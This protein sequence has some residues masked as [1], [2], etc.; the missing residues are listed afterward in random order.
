MKPRF[1]IDEN[2][3]LDI[4]PGVRRHDA[5]IDITHVGDPGAPPFRTPDPTIL[6][7]CERER[8]ILVTKNRKS[9]PGHIADH[10]RTGHHHWGLLSVKTGREDDIGGLIESLVLVW[11]IQ[12]AEEYLDT[13]DWIPF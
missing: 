10:L 8:R 9:M 4:T 1:L 2:L 5:T 6:D 11:E 12:K 7:Y 3:S 13:Q